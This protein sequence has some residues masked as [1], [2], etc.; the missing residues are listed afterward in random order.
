MKQVWDKLSAGCNGRPLV[1]VRVA[2]GRHSPVNFAATQEDCV[3]EARREA[4]YG[5]SFRRVYLVM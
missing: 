1:S 4:L 3:K 2:M 5:M